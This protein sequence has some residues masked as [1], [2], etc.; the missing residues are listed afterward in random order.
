MPYRR[1]RAALQVGDAAD[2]GRKDHVRR[3]LAE[4][5]VQHAQFAIAQLVRQFGVQHRIRA[6]R[7]AAQVRF[8]ARGAQLEAELVQ[9][10][11]HP[12]AQLLPMLQ[13]AGGV[14]GVQ[15]VRLAHTALQLGCQLGQH[16]R[17]Q[18]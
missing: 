18:F 17:Q 8:V 15:G 10:R 3:L 14:V 6:R 1:A 4:G 7:A 9:V 12:T 2:V 11:L 16:G 5:F 13:G